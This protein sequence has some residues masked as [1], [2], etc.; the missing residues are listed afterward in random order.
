MKFLLLIIVHVVLFSEELEVTIS[1]IKDTNGVLF[2]GLF[3]ENNKFLN[4]NDTYQAQ[5]IEINKRD[6]ITTLFKLPKTSYAITIFHDENN[7]KKLDKNFFGIPKEG[8]GFSNNPKI[9]FSEPSFKEYSFELK[10]HKKITIK[11]EY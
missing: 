11:M 5:Q 8:F 4:L 2:I 10:E 3:K 7:N 1:H 9:S 6:S